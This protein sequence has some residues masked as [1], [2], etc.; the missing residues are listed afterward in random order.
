MTL[1][2]DVLPRDV[3]RWKY[4][5]SFW[6]SHCHCTDVQGDRV[7]AD[8]KGMEWTMAVVYVFSSSGRYMLI[9]QEILQAED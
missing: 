3:T 4:E 5:D 1:A 2:A 8:T 7:K 6:C 9:L